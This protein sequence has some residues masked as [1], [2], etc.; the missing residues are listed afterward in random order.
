MDDAIQ[1]LG[2]DRLFDG[3]GHVMES[4]GVAWRGARIVAVGPWDALLQ[5]H[6]PHA[7]AAYHRG[8]TLLPGLIDLHTH[9]IMPGTGVDLMRWSAETDAVLLLTALRNCHLALQSGV[10]TVVDFGARGTLTFDLRTALERTGT[11]APRLLLCGRALTITGGHAWPW[12]GEADGVDGVRQAVRQLCKEGA[13]LIK[14]MVSGGGTPG[15]DG[16][17]PSFTQAELNALVDEA[18]A[19][20]RPVAGHCTAARAIERALD[21]GID[22]VAHAQFLA[23]DGSNRFEEGLAQRMAE[24]GTVV[25]PTLQINR[26]LASARVNRAAMDAAQCARHDA[27]VARYPEFCDAFR[28]LRA[29]G[30]PM[31]CG[32]DCGWGYSTFDEIHLELDAMVEAGM[33]PREALAAATGGAADA[34]G[35]GDRI[36]RC[37]PGFAADL[38]LVEGDPTHAVRDLVHVRGVWRGGQP[39]HGAARTAPVRPL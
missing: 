3:A 25:N 38:L 36:G 34:L 19:R 28:R 7:R 20:G 1:L 21:A 24:Q 16:R 9:L 39:V 2:A 23:P 5:E 29:A 11:L 37:A 35:W 4:A 33:P 6:G 12:H 8:C 10:T 32:S 14:V 26:I 22:I 13:D 27:W 30:V 17:R 15:T 31:V 18:H